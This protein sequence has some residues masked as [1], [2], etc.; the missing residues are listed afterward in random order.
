MCTYNTTEWKHP[1]SCIATFLVLEP[2]GN[3]VLVR[4]HACG[5]CRT[6]L[7]VVEGELPQRQRPLIPGHQVV[8][9]LKQQGSARRA[10]LSERALERRGCTAPAAFVLTAV[11]GQ[12]TCARVPNSPVIRLTEVMRNT[13]EGSVAKWAH[14]RFGRMSGR[15]DYPRGPFPSSPELSAYGQTDAGTRIVDASHLRVRGRVQSFTEA[16]QALPTLPND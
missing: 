5:I 3:D 13:F 2:V 10:L 1:L 14:R 7:H 8:G 11:A 4:V 15:A 6:D 12:R 16:E 9:M